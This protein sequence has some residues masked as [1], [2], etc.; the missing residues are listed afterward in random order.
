MKRGTLSPLL[1]YVYL[2]G[3][4]FE[5][6]SP[7]SHSLIFHLIG[8]PFHD[9]AYVEELRDPLRRRHSHDGNRRISPN[10]HSH[11]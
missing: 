3:T 7:S 1:V 9:A 5:H 2:R 11:R 4:L 8:E 6:V 10:P